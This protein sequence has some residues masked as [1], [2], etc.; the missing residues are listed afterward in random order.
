[1][2]LFLWENELLDVK[3]NSKEWEIGNNDAGQAVDS[4][5]SFDREL[6]FASV[7]RHWEYDPRVNFSESRSSE[8]G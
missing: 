7:K 3:R 2:Y 4:C 5:T 8:N 6:E 1:M